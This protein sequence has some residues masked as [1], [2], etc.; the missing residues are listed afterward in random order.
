MSPLP[1]GYSLCARNTC[2]IVID[3]VGIVVQ[4]VGGNTTRGFD[5][6][7]RSSKLARVSVGTLCTLNTNIFPTGS[8]EEQQD[9]IR[10][11]HVLSFRCHKIGVSNV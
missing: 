5:F 10:I 1:A 3:M 7:R 11:V 8:G 2:Q 4:R 9:T 6:T